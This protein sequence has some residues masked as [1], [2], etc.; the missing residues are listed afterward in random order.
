MMPRSLGPVAWVTLILLIVAG[1]V[2]LSAGGSVAPRAI[3][4]H[5]SLDRLQA[6]SGRP[7]NGSIV[8]TNMTNADLTVESCAANGWLSVGLHGPVD[9]YPFSHTAIRCAPTV[10]LVPGPNRFPITVITT[11]AA[12]TEAE[13]SGG[14]APTRTAPACTESGL[15]PLP[16]GEYSTKVDIVG[17]NGLTGTPNRVVIRLVR[18]GRRPKPAT[19]TNHRAPMPPVIVPNVIGES[20]LVAASVFAKVCLNAVYAKPGGDSVTSEAPLPGSLVAE[21]A[22]VTLT[23]R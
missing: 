7:I 23:T 2:P 15:P 11:Y 20:S 21:H 6:V 19:C 1:C 8:L 14:A 9:S 16:G 13:P 4:V 12:C 10:R 3:R 22:T 5:V 17:L 18:P